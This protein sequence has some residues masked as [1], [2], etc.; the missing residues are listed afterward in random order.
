MAGQGDVDQQVVGPSAR[1]ARARSRPRPGRTC[2]AAP[3]P[4]PPR[5]PARHRSRAARVAPRSARR[6]PG[7]PSP[8]SAI[9][10]RRHRPASRRR[11]RPAG[12]PPA[13]T[14]RATRSSGGSRPGPVRRR[15]V[16]HLVV[17][18]ARTVRTGPSAAELDHRQASGRQ[19]GRS[20]AATEP[21]TLVGL[22]GR[23]S[24]GDFGA[25]WQLAAASRSTGSGRRAARSSANCR[26]ACRHR[27]VLDDQVA[28]TLEPVGTARGSRCCRSRR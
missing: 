27:G 5:A 21:T 28:G 22:P 23:G 25:G 20:S 2:P 17:P 6:S 9:T 26:T 10:G 1:R 8:A 15:V 19:P 14:S 7:S 12:P 13:G 4:G 18:A 24:G 11:R 16:H 3:C